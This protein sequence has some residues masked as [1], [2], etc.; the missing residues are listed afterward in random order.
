MMSLS[1]TMCAQLVAAGMLSC[2]CPRNHL[3][4]RLPP[5]PDSPV[6]PANKNCHWPTRINMTRCPSRFRTPVQKA[7][8]H[9]SSSANCRSRAA[10][11]LSLSA[12]YEVSFFAAVSL[13]S[14]TSEALATYCPAAPPASFSFDVRRNYWRLWHQVSGDRS[15]SRNG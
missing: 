14:V 9:V 2:H 12:S 3:P 11:M 15:A 8:L 6:A 1:A 13:T 4:L 10:R 7:D 5:R